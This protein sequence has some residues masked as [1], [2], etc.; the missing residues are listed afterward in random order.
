MAYTRAFEE[1]EVSPEVRRAYCDIR[2]SFDLP[3]VPT[4]FKLVSSCPAYL[5]GM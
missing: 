1:H 5:K 4:V 2:S 3:F